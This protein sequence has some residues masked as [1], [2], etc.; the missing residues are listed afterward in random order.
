MSEVDTK[1]ISKSFNPNIFKRKT[2]LREAKAIFTTLLAI[3]IVEKNLSG[4]LRKYLAFTAYRLFF[5]ARSSTLI[6][7]A[8]IK[9]ISEEEKNALRT[10][11]KS[12]SNKSDVIDKSAN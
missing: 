3:R 8:T 5:L 9:A 7:F 6:L 1:S 10:N 12:S 2:E 4:C 11:K